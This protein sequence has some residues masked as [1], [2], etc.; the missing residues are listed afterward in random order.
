[1]AGIRSLIRYPVGIGIAGSVFKENKIVISQKGKGEKNFYEIDNVGT[2]AEI[3]NFIFMP[4]Y[5]LG[6]KANG[7]VQF[8]NKKGEELNQDQIEILKPYQK[9]LG[10]MIEHLLELN[11]AMDI[12]MCINQVI[13]AMNDKTYIN[14]SEV[15]IN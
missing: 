11:A 7:V 4:T 3:K 6:G 8:Y 12:S 9:L 2:Y 10:H 15:L 5:G 1:M 13:D 14:E